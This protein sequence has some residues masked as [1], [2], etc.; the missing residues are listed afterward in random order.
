VIW[1]SLDPTIQKRDARFREH[2][3]EKMLVIPAQAGIS[4][5]TQE[6]NYIPM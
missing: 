6:K 3:N 4:D 2:D 5:T 1:S